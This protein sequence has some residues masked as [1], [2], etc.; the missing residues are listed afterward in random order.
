MNKNT[1]RHSA[2]RRKLGKAIAIQPN[3]SKQRRVKRLPRLKRQHFALYSSFSRQKQHYLGEFLGIMSVLQE[4]PPDL[5]ANYL[6]RFNQC[7]PLKHTMA[8]CSRTEHLPSSAPPKCA[9]GIVAARLLCSL[10]WAALPS[11]TGSISPWIV[12]FLQKF[13]DFYTQVTP[14]HA[15]FGHFTHTG[16]APIPWGLIR[17]H[18]PSLVWS[19]PKHQTTPSA[20]EVATK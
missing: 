8:S 13:T 14:C 15:L 19:R 10:L 11:I 20:F 5:L 6:L 17:R 16:R 3:S 12:D 1:C 7:K 18:H 4:A 2:T 9:G